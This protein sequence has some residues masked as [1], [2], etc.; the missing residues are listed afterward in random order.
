MVINMSEKQQTTRDK[1]LVKIAQLEAQL[2]KQRARLNAEKR[3]ERNGQ[4]IAM[5]IFMEEYLKDRPGR[6]PSIMQAM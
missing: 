6:I 2:Q 1:R 4:F 5:G 3:K